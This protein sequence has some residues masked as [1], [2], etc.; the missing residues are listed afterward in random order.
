MVIPDA[1]VLRRAAIGRLRARQPLARVPRGPATM[2]RFVLLAVA[3]LVAVAFATP[4]ASAGHCAP[5]DF[6][7]KV[8]E[9]C[10]QALTGGCDVTVRPLPDLGWIQDSVQHLCDHW[11]QKCDVTTGSAPALLP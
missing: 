1:V 2:N 6:V 7:C 10:D 8:I 9:L 5:R 11:I 4:A 3:S